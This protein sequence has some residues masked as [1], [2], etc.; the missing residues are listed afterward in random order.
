MH[1]EIYLSTNWNLESH[2]VIKHEIW[3]NLWQEC[4]YIAYTHIAYT[5]I[6]Q[7]EINEGIC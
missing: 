3:F 4:F 5:H 1:D 6:R 7:N 2:D